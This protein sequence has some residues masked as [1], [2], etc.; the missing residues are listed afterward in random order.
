[1]PE[2][3]QTL[4]EESITLQEHVVRLDQM[5]DFKQPEPE[6]AHHP[7]GAQFSRLRA[8]FGDKVD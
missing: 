6:D 2:R 5:M 3:L 4:I 7:V 1:L 8:A